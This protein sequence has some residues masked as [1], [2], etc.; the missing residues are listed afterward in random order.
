MAREAYLKHS[1]YKIRN[2]EETQ[3][4]KNGILLLSVQKAFVK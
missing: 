2:I 3:L 1:E 4:E